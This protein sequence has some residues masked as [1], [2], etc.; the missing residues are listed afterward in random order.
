M[1]KKITYVT[2]EVDVVNMRTE[3]SILQNSTTETLNAKNGY[4]GDQPEQ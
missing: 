4:W 1:N 3:N 2:P